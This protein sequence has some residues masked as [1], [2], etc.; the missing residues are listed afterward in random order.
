M[1]ACNGIKVASIVN[2]ANINIYH[3]SSIY[4]Q[5][6]KEYE[7][8]SIEMKYLSLFS[9]ELNEEETT[10]YLNKKY[11]KELFKKDIPNNGEYIFENPY[12]IT[13]HV[14]DLGKSSGSTNEQVY[15]S[16]NLIGDKLIGFGNELKLNLEKKNGDERIV[17]SKSKEKVLEYE[18]LVYESK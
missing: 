4:I 15:Y 17:F 11:F 14:N 12:I 8:E 5:A 6:D 2:K 18:L 1:D 13:I 3:L 10:L 7:D 9:Q 16:V